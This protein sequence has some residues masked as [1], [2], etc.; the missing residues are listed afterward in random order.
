MA[1]K[2]S[3][4]S[5]SSLSLPRAKRLCRFLTMISESSRSRRIIMTRLKLDLRTF[6]RDLEYLRSL[7]I[8][9]TYYHESYQMV[10]SLDEALHRIPF[11]DPGLSVREAILLARGHSEAHRKLRRRLDMLLGTKSAE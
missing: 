9:I 1:R 8:E 6:Y 7:G 5:P 2:K 4:S 10:G 3:E 11:P